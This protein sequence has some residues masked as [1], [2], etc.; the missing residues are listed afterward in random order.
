MMACHTIADIREEV[1]KVVEDDAKPLCCYT[2]DSFH[3]NNIIRSAKE[4]FLKENACISQLKKIHFKQNVFEVVHA[5]QMEELHS[6]IA[7]M[8]DVYILD[9]TRYLQVPAVRVWFEWSPKMREKYVF[10]VQKLSVED[11]LKQKDVPWPVV[12][13]AHLDTT[14]FRALKL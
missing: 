7:R 4:T 5:H 9:H 2:N 8:S 3:I 13:S 1:G 6:A 10:G 11:V 12:E 14:E